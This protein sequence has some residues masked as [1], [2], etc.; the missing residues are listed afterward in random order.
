MLGLAVL[1]S[2]DF[3]ALIKDPRG[4]V[5]M[6]AAALS[7]SI[8]NVLLK[9][10]QWSVSPLALTAWFFA[11][12]AVVCVPLAWHFESPAEQSWP[13][14]SVCLVMVY[15]VFGPMVICYAIWT[16]LVDRLPTTIAAL[17]ALTAPV[18][19]VVSSVLL[20]NEPLTGQKLLSLSLIVL[21]VA[22]TFAGP[23]HP[24]SEDEDEARLKPSSDQ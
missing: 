12:S 9:A 18:F 13:S 1:A 16:S 23:R 10:R 17:A 11:V 8:G 3:D 24:H 5:V 22:L 7:W 6:L 4:L 14:L 19:G 21:S 15:H 2:E 20:I